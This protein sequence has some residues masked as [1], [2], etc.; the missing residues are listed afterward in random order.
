MFFGI[1]TPWLIRLRYLR[2]RNSSSCISVDLRQI[3][4]SHS[5]S[6]VCLLMQN[7]AAE[8]TYNNLDVTLKQANEHRNTWFEGVQKCHLDDSLI[9]VMEK[10]V[11]A[12]VRTSSLRVSVF[13]S[14]LIRFIFP[15]VHRLV[16]VDNEDKVIGVIS[17]SDILKELVLKPCRKS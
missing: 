16:V 14:E 17:L 7:L 3:S 8:K 6:L 5:S 1:A 12:E 10:I 2:T 11:R 4:Q 13:Q 9:T 15:Q